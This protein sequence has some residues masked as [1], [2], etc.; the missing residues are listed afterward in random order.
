MRVHQ[1][2][3][4]LNVECSLVANYSRCARPA[5]SAVEMS[6]GNKMWRCVFHRGMRTVETGPVHYDVWMKTDDEA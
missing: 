6:N 3:A 2:V 1:R 4:D 5:D